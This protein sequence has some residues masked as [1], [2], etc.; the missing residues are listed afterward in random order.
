LPDTADLRSVSAT[1]AENATVTTVDGREFV[2]A[3]SGRT[4]SRVPGI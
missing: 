4:W 3:D 2:T 1:D